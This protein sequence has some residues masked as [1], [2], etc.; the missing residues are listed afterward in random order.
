[1]ALSSCSS[2][3]L[4]L[5]LWC[6]LPPSDASVATITIIHH[7]P[8]NFAIQSPSQRHLSSTKMS[9]SRSPYE[10]NPSGPRFMPP[11][12]S[13]I[14]LA[15]GDRPLAKP[16]CQPLLRIILSNPTGGIG[17]RRPKLPVPLPSSPPPSV[18][19]RERFVTDAK[20]CYSS[21]SSS[22]LVHRHGDPDAFPVKMCIPEQPS[23]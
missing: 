16:P 17:P 1:M 23:P 18:P 21:S 19:H 4:Y 22:A 15:S 9:S 10:E 11:S 3:L 5:Y 20:S 14:V 7:S 12:S 8:S 6:R 2:P 13:F